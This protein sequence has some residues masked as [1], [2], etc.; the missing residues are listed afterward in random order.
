VPWE[1]FKLVDTVA[2]HSLLLRFEVFGDRVWEGA[3]SQAVV[4]FSHKRG[5]T[6]RTELQGLASVALVDIIVQLGN[7]LVERRA[8]GVKF[9]V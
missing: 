3:A 1:G 9:W 6:V 4:I 8:S 2:Y 7:L 5:T